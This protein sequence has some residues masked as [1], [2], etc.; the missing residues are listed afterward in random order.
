M[1]TSRRLPT[2]ENPPGSDPR[3]WVGQ[4]QHPASWV[5]YGQEYGLVSLFKFCFKIIATLCGGYFFQGA[6][7]LCANVSRGVVVVVYGLTLLAYLIGSLG[8][9]V[10][11][12]S[13]KQPLPIV[14][15]YSRLFGRKDSVMSTP[16]VYLNTQLTQP[17]FAMNSQL[18]CEKLFAVSV[19]NQHKM[20]KTANK[21]TDFNRFFVII[22]KRLTLRQ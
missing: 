2:R 6:G 18:R 10:R 17:I 1:E 13:D 7:S 4:G 3:T 22:I 14:T 8:W 12:V 11:P 15:A 5:G 20:S 9:G 16:R 21:K 19:K